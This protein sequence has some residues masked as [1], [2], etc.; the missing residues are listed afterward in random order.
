MSIIRNAKEFFGLTPVDMEHEDAYYDDDREYRSSGSAAYAP[1]PAPAPTRDW[2][3]PERPRYAE[4][5][6]VAVEVTTYNQAADIGEPFRNG[7]AVVFDL[8]R[9]EPGDN[10]RIVDFA[11][12]LCF[13]L[14][15]RMINVS[16][17]VETDRR[18]FAIT[19]EGANFSQIELERASGLR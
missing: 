13:A 10:K 2:D 18:V 3:Y 6:L 8:S 16:K 7:D 9:M 15:G 5:K 4:P 19:P 1:A 17:H 14:R 12:G 11:A